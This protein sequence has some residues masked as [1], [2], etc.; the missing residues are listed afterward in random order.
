MVIGIGIDLVNI[1]RIEKAVLRWS[2][3]FRDRVF[4]KGELGYCDRQKHPAAHLAARFGVKEAAL[5]AF[6][7]GL[8]G[9]ATWKDIEV[10][11]GESGQPGIVFSGRLG[12]LAQEK[13]V[14]GALVSMSHDSGFAVA[15]VVLTGEG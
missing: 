15:Q 14:T 10:V 11:R 8:S 12:R 3:A 4:T 13:G 7:T 6:G 9:G 1:E 5:K 2:D